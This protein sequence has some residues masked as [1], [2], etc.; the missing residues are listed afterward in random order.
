M[1]F[2]ESKQEIM[3][4]QATD[5]GRLMEWKPWNRWSMRTRQWNKVVCWNGNHGMDGNGTRSSAGMETMERMTRKQGRLM[6]WNGWSVKTKNGTGQRW[7]GYH[8]INGQMELDQP[9][10]QMEQQTKQI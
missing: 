10:T 9:M 4:K 7:N 8:D 2:M 6:E 1:G 5:Q 3:G